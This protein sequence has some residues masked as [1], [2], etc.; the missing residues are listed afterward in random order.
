MTIFMQGDDAN[1]FIDEARA[2]GYPIVAVA[3][4]DGP[5]SP[6]R[7]LRIPCIRPSNR[8]DIVT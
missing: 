2:M 6:Y 8:G 3:V 5:L 7:A 4:W 1:S